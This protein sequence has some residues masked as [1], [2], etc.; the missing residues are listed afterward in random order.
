MEARRTDPRH[1]FV[2]AALG[3]K[4]LRERNSNAIQ[5]L[6]DSVSDPVSALPFQDLAEALTR[7]GRKAEASDVLRRAIARFPFE[8]VPWKRLISVQIS[9][10]QYEAARASMT[11]YL[12]LFPDDEFMRRRGKS[13][14][15]IVTINSWP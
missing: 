3:R 2:L 6:M 11:Q 1:P 7:D 5:Y 9:L 8:P 4:A 13:E 15:E 10:G 14:E 12:Y